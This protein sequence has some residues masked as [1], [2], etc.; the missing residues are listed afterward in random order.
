[1][2]KEL[3]LTLASCELNKSYIG[4]QRHLGVPIGLVMFVIGALHY[5]NYKIQ[6]D[7]RRFIRLF[8]HIAVKYKKGPKK[9]KTYFAAF[10][11]CSFPRSDLL[12]YAHKSK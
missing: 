8:G 11:G 1:M 3:Q 2:D 5:H 12:F 4:L 10:V 7:R 6:V 9:N